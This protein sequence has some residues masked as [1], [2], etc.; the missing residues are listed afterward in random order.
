MH[1]KTKYKKRID[2]KSLPSQFYKYNA[3]TTLT[4]YHNFYIYN[5][6]WYDGSLHEFSDTENTNASITILQHSM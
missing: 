1:Q 6:F 3:Y 2:A 4:L 5:N